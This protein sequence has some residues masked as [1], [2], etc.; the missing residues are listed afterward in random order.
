MHSR[1][2]IDYYSVILARGLYTNKR[3]LRNHLKGIFGEYDFTHKRV[4]E[5]GGGSG[6]LSFYAASQ[7]AE[8]VICLEPE[9]AGSTSGINSHFEET[10]GDLGLN[11]VRLE[12]LTLQS[13][14]PDGKKFDLVLLHNSINH[15]DEEACI[16]LLLTD[17]ARDTYRI[18]FHSLGALAN[19]GATLIICDCSRNNLF[20]L[21]GIKHPLAGMIE[22][23]K[24]QA[25]EVWA[26]LLSDHGF[27]QP[28]ITWLSYNSLGWLGRAL[29]GNKWVSYLLMSRFRLRMVKA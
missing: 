14:N 21:L 20:A 25:P 28:R 15:L 10:R 9:A 3:N 16:N 11:N 5:V 6:L 17:K 22:W 27:S 26:R 23:H 7:G 12:K 24:H 18:I 19:P 2:N 13:F 1:Q 4:L 8:E 29:L